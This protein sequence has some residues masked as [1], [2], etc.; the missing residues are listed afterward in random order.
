M[1]TPMWAILMVNG[2][3][4]FNSHTWPRT[5][6]I[7]GLPSKDPTMKLQVTTVNLLSRLSQRDCQPLTTVT[8]HWLFFFLLCIGFKDTCSKWELN[9]LPGKGQITNIWGFVGH[10]FS[11]VT[12]QLCCCRAEASRDTVWLSSNKTCVDTDIWISNNFSCQEIL[13]F[14]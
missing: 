7:N 3:H 9:K 14:F 4:L 6:W 8:V 2:S 11:F 12:T 5:P 10:L 1:G 13:C